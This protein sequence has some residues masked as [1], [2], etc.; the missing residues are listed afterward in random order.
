MKTK[1]L[2]GGSYN[3]RYGRP[4]LA[5]K[6]EVERLLKKHNLDF[7][8]VQEAEDYWRV[9]NNIK[10]YKYFSTRTYRGGTENGILVREGLKTSK[11]MFD[12]F[13]DGWITDRGGNHAPVSLSRVKIAGW[14]RVGSIHAPTPIYFGKSGPSGPEE[15]LDDFMLLMKKVY[16]YL[17]FAGKTSKIIVG[18]WNE[19]LSTKTPWSPGWIAAKTKATV[20]DTESTSG[21]GR[22]DYPMGKNVKF[23]RVFKDL[24]I[25]EN[26]DHEPVIFTV[27]KA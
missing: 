12:S 20:K 3:L 6:S 8:A 27:S 21:F 7:L 25:N 10:G 1:K 14:L 11:P 26:S 24:E 23:D 19:P 18:D 2:Q 22:I 15:R 17:K 9:L 13:G 16:R 5:V 4:Q